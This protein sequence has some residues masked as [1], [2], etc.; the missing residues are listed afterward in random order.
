[1]DEFAKECE[2]EAELF[3]EAQGGMQVSNTKIAEASRKRQALIERA[4]HIAS[5]VSVENVAKI[6]AAH[7][8]YVDVNQIL[9]FEIDGAMPAWK[10]YEQDATAIVRKLTGG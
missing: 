3:R 6:I 9:H 4:L 10:I 8:G 2:R 7:R 5:R 1:M